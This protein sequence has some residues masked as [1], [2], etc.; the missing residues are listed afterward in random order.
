MIILMLES[1]E[2]PLIRP[3]S[4]ILHFLKLFKYLC[5]P[6]Y[7]GDIHIYVKSVNPTRILYSPLS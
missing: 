3:K 2:L 4:F 1:M 6:Q 7:I 5:S